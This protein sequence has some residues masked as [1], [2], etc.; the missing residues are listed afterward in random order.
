MLTAMVPLHPHLRVLT[1]QGPVGFALLI[2]S[3]GITI[4]AA[5]L[6]PEDSSFLALLV[7]HRSGR[8]ECANWPRR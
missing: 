6:G 3:S 8:T 7:A 2:S 1:Q 5:C 4:L